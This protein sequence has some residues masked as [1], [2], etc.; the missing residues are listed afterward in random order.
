MTSENFKSTVNVKN[1]LALSSFFAI[2]AK[3][4]NDLSAVSVLMKND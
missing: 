2:K 1:V 4:L 3:K